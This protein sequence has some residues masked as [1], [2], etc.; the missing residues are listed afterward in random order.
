MNQGTPYKSRFWASASRECSKRVFEEND[1][2]CGD[3]GSTIRSIWIRFETRDCY[4]HWCQKLKQFPYDSTDSCQFL[5][6]CE[7]VFSQMHGSE[8]DFYTHAPIYLEKR[9]LS[10]KLS[11]AYQSQVF[12]YVY[13]F[14][15]YS[16]IIKTHTPV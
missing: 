10:R 16:T 7:S 1:E 5:Q 3:D 8:V 14:S 2:S 4:N 11:K 9:P 6:N 15:D 12:K 13:V